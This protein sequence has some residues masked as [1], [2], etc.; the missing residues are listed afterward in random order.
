M[1][2]C[3]HE[4]LTPYYFNGTNGVQGFVCDDCKEEVDL[5]REALKAISGATSPDQSRMSDAERKQLYPFL[6]SK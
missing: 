5:M 1:K 3:K 6:A 2:N 4:N